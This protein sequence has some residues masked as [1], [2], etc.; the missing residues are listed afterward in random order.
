MKLEKQDRDDRG[1][2]T[3]EFAI[4][5]SVLMLLVFGILSVGIFIN[6]HM[7]AA[8]KARQQARTAALAC[9]QADITAGKTVSATVTPTFPWIVPLVPKPAAHPQTVTYRCGG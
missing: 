5:G 6:A 8:D 3:I 9:S 1:L 4:V 7:Q 2:A